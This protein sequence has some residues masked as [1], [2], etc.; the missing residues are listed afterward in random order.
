M[1]YFYNY[2][3]YLIDDYSGDR[4][5]SKRHNSLGSGYKLEKPLVHD[6]VKYDSEDRKKLYSR[7]N[8]IDNNESLN[9]NLSRSPTKDDE[10]DE[11][12]KART[13]RK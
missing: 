9:E 10:E 5:R 12:I 13:A 11:K 4:R 7:R 6:P 8:Y 1:L 2:K 3:Q